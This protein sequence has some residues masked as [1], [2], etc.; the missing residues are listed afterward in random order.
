MNGIDFSP[1]TAISNAAAWHLAAGLVRQHPARLR[2]I[3]L[4]PGGGMY[5]CLTVM[6]QGR[7]FDESGSLQL[8]RGGSAHVWRYFDG[9][10][11]HAGGPKESFPIWGDSLANEPRE[12][13]HALSERMR[14]AVPEHLPSSTP[15]SVTYRALAEFA[16]LGCFHR[17]A[18]T[19]TNGFFDTSGYGGGV[20]QEAFE[21]FPGALLAMRTSPDDPLG[22]SAYQYW[23]LRRGSE[24]I[25]CAHDSGR[26]WRID[27][28]ECD[29][30]AAFLAAGRRVWPALY[31]LVGSSLR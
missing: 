11:K 24:L 2:I 26:A 14:L 5:D 10:R 12:V 23:F 25:A 22:S 30:F 15:A 27:G 6:E 21:R 17:E 16:G 20:D 4:H 8:N 7:P 9:E 19:V 29:L 28:A 13:I 31:S 18:W 3:E 1:T